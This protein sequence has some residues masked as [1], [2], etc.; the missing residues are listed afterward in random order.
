MP[1]NDPTSIVEGATGRALIF[2]R[3][4]NYTKNSTFLD[5]AAEYIANTMKHISS[6]PAS[7]SYFVGYG[8]IYIVAAQ[9]AQ[10]QNNKNEMDKYLADLVGV[11]EDVD[12]AIKNGDKTSSKYK[13]DMMD[14]CLMTGLSGLLY[15]GILSNEYFGESTINNEYIT[16]LGHY[17]ISMGLS[18]AQS[19]GDNSGILL[20]KFGYEAGCYLPGSAEGNGGAIKMLLEA[21]R[22]GYIPDLM[23]NKT[24]HDAIENTLNWFVS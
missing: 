16:D 5:I 11:F 22:R 10:M 9:I 19:A 18:T 14:G 24:Y 7:A 21:Y 12:V 17:L 13:I 1:L 15:S 6:A 8:G 3:M 2:L 20:Y 4:Y 23:T